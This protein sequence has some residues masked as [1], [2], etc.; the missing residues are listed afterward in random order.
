MGGG[1]GGTAKVVKNNR[2]MVM[3]DFEFQTDKQLLANQHDIVVDS[4]TG[5]KGHKKIESYQGQEEKLE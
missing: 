2:G 5:K 1:G 3:S 4:N